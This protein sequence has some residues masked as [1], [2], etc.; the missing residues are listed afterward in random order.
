MSAIE[1][2][3]E[4]RSKYLKL[5]NRFGSRIGI[6]FSVSCPRYF[7]NLSHSRYFQPF[8]LLRIWAWTNYCG[9]ARITVRTGDWRTLDGCTGR[10]LCKNE[11]DYRRESEREREYLGVLATAG[12]RYEGSRIRRFHRDSFLRITCVL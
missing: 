10:S 2:R 8:C 6:L 4:E 3:G 12:A 1:Q 9:N 11:A 7:D 5:V